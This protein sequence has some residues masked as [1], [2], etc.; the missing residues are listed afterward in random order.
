M[1]ICRA[2][3][4]RGLLSVFVSLSSMAHAQVSFD[5]I[6]VDPQHFKVEYEDTKVRVL[7]F[8]LAPGE[9]SPM[10]EHAGRTVVSMTNSKVRTVSFY[11]EVR[12]QAFHAGEALHL[13]PM[14]YAVE[15]I[16]SEAVETVSTEF[17]DQGYVTEALPPTVSA[18]A[19]AP[20]QAEVET[21]RSIAPTPKRE[22]TTPAI[23]AR[24][25]AAP[26]PAETRTTENPPA[27]SKTQPQ[28]VEAA[29]QP[30]VDDHPVPAFQRA[31]PEGVVKTVTV[32]GA[33][34]A[35]VD[36]GQG[37][38]VIFLHDTLGDYRSWAKVIDPLSS[39]GQFRVISYSRR[40]HYPNY[41]NGKER[42]YNFQQNEKDLA[43]FIRSLKVAAVTLVG[44][45]YG[46]ALAAAVA[47]KNP[48]LVRR[49]A[50][51]DP[52]FAE[53]LPAARAEASRATR[54]EIY[55]IIR[56]P[57]NKGQID[58]ALETYVDWGKGSQT[59]RHLS[60]DARSEYK[61]NSNA[62]KAQTYDAPSPALSCAD[63]RK[64]KAP[65][66]LLTG[67]L[68]PPNTHDAASALSSCL[69]NGKNVQITGREYVGYQVDGAALSQF[70][71]TAR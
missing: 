37:P 48:E 58:A 18:K 69:P 2:G 35:Y 55:H 61:Q 36:H 64:I 5:P 32:N 29:A 62:L 3:I 68:A 53:L 39:S 63:F 27:L 1:R 43:D 57:L 41:S 22:P 28:P 40:Y 50:I 24:K 34:L 23:A 8:R 70:L 46:S 19:S 38:V 56:K 10:Q 9:K 42:D 47:E 31:T 66:L 44:S 59:W 71:A 52:D 6:R 4:C 60:A 25:D 26:K 7:R 30:A 14:R 33:E 49:I 12:E 65:V 13:L 21:S 11:G 45:G 20:R 67:E 54:D 51:A 15:N 17:K 16:G